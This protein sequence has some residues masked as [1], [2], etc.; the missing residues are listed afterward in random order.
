M[1]EPQTAPILVLV[2]GTR[3]EGASFAQVTAALDDVDI[4]IVTYDRRGWGQAPEWDGRAADLAD[5]ADDLLAVIGERPATVI[6]HSLGG[7]V[8]ITAAIRRPELF[9]S[10]GLWETAM[11]W[12]PWWQGDQ[13]RLV[14]GA[15]SRMEQKPP[16]TSRQNRER[17]LFVAEA[18]EGLSQ[19]YDL[20]R[21]HTRC[22]VGYGTAT[23]PDFGPGMNAL[24]GV[25]GAEVF[26]LPG[27]T[28]MAHREEP[29][30]FARF[31]RQAIALGRTG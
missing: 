13:P 29:E 28:H 26:A 27:A 4:E 31:V 22:V 5:H 20:A 2:H 7:N 18:T 3:D 24:A 6:G 19:S 9:L 15:I 14:R 12:A 8:A 23:R 16:G 30:G 21:L 25:I 11:A 1:P 10:L 17:Q